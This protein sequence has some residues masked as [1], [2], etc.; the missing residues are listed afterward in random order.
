MRLGGLRK[1]V[2]S[3]FG[4]SADTMVVLVFLGIELGRSA[5][6]ASFDTFLVFVTATMVLT[7]PYVLLSEERPVFTKWL[8]G[9]SLVVISASLVGT[10][11][12][13]FHTFVPESVRFLPLSLLILAGMTSCFIQFYGLMRLRLAK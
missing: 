3:F 9:R 13:Q 8:I 2:D 4:F 1:E 10:M 7:L 11:L 5:T 12:E 6:N